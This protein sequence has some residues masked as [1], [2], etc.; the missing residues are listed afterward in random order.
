MR[1]IDYKKNID[2]L[3][4][5]SVLAV[6]FFHL[7]PQLFPGGFIGVDI[8]FVISGYLISKIICEQIDKKEFKI[9]N[10]I[11]SR[12]R[13]I[14]PML[15]FI[16]LVFFP[17]LFFLLPAKMISIS[18]SI[19]SSI[20]FVSNILFYL[21]SGYFG[22]AVNLKPYIH[23]WS[24]S[25]EEQFY[26]IFP[27]FCL[28]FYKKKF[29][30]VSLIILFLIS[31]FLANFF[32]PKFPNANF[33]LTPTRIWELIAGILF[34]FFEKKKINFSK[35]IENIICSI[36]LIII[37][38]SFKYLNNLDQIP[39]IKL[40]PAIIGTGLLIIY[41]GS[42]SFIKKIL[43]N[44]LLVFVGLISYSLYMLHQPILSFN[45]NLNFFEE[46]IFF[47]I[48]FLILL[49]LFS[50]TTWKFV[51]QPFR[52]N[53][54][55][56]NKKFF[57]LISI[58][59]LF[60]ITINLVILITSGFVNKFDKKDR[61]LALLNPLNEGRYVSKKFNAL[62]YNN[63]KEFDKKNIYILGD[64]HAQDFIN[65]VYEN[66]FFNGFDV[67]TY[68]FHVECYLKFLE[69]NNETNLKKLKKCKKNIPEDIIYADTIF[70]VNVWEPWITTYL[71]EIF[72][73]RIFKNKKI[74]LIGTKNFGKI[75]IK[76][77]LKKTNDERLN[78]RFKLPYK[79]I[80]LENKIKLS[81]SNIF[82]IS[83][84][85]LYCDKN[86]S[87]TIFTDKNELISYDGGHLTKAGAKFL[88]ESL[89]KYKRLEIYKKEK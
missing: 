9:I 86:Y 14:L 65:M 74:F 26:I 80:E 17:L 42:S 39:N 8:F 27:I 66:N 19:L 60:I 88:G 67:K 13:R 37:F 77:L 32:G 63:F 70:L 25:V 3:R 62:S 7:E 11:T 76:D 72:E 23:L 89:F 10:F 71:K 50:A 83:P 79:F 4:G 41:G 48:S 20:F 81:N 68:S 34:M 56:S 2:G 85:N 45:K 18:E 28:L 31:F 46:T 61:Y 22:E 57:Y 21:E 64:S 40:L 55:I 73:N 78:Y 16:L 35:S 53:K 84:Y 69:E 51:E 52:D 43:C 5:I 30:L 29:F 59:G 38:I 15:F 49:L 87:C 54:K 12:S 6:I 82:Y 75:N 36:S 33:F 47:K 44:K 1:G 58:I 24:L